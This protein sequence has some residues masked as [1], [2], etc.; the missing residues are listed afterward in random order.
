MEECEYTD[1]NLENTNAVWKKMN[2]Y[3]RCGEK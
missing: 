3:T 2:A 1:K